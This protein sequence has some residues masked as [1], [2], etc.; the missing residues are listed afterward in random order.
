ATIRGVE[1]VDHDDL[2]DTSASVPNYLFFRRDSQ[3]KRY[4]TDVTDRRT[5]SCSAR[6]RL[7]GREDRGHHR[8]VVEAGR[9]VPNLSFA[10]SSIFQRELVSSSRRVIPSSQRVGNCATYYCRSTSTGADT[11]TSPSGG[12]QVRSR[13]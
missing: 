4:R 3:N 2:H 8:G 6:G 13:S 11:D 12:C 10:K 5:P 9:A 7:S 1:P